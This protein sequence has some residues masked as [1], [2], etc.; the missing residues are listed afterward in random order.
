MTTQRLADMLH[1]EVD[2]IDFQKASSVFK[3]Q[4]VSDSILLCDDE[5]TERQYAFMRALKEYAMLNEERHEILEHR[6]Y[7]EG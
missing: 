5:P 1:R 4:I 3:A 7:K 2:L 6:G